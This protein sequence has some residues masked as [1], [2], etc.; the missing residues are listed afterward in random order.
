MKIIYIA[1]VR[2]P[3]EKAHGIQIMK[4]CEA[5]ARGGHS[6]ELVVPD[7]HSPIPDDP[8]S[9]Y[10]IQHRFPLTKLFTIDTVGW[11]SLGYTFQSVMF[12]LRAGLYARGR[13]VD[14]IYGR[15]EIVLAMVS[16]LTRKKMIWESH[17]GM[18]NKW[19]RFVA[20]RVNG[21]VVVTQGAIDFYT[22][23]GIPE[24][25]LLAV[26]NGIDLDDFAHPESKSQSR[27]RLGLPQDAKIAL[28]IGKLDG[29]KGVDTLLEASKL[30][31]TVRVCIIGGTDAQGVELS[32][33]YPHVIFLGFKPFTELPNNQ[34]AADVLVVPNTA[35]DP[36]SVRF[37]SPL[38]LI[39]HMASGRP[40][41]VSD[42]PSTRWLADG[43]AFF[44]RPDDPRAL[45]HEIEHALMSPT[46][47][48]QLVSLAAAR[49]QSL[50]WTQRVEKIACFIEGVARIC[51]AD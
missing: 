49:A 20:K 10:G 41:V 16:L 18:W 24:E 35:K 32:E 22:E 31:K 5:F 7:R 45:A 50:S 21:I 51:V 8:F 38:K 2:L 14:V 29:W 9:Y 4:A 3:T 43:A 23:Q 11:G 12:G 19:A 13:G 37:T 15:D 36:I 6:L 1:N 28:Y 48:E 44:V 30:M 42:L 47:S 40:V 39:A 17:D 34:A 33:K 46:E 26:S 27:A 25:K